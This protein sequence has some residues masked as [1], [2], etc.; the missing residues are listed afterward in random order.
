MLKQF[1]L[2]PLCA[3][4]IVASLGAGACFLGDDGAVTCDNYAA[5]Q[6]S[7]TGSCTPT[8]SCE[9]NYYNLSIN[10][11]LALDHCSDC[12]VDNLNGGYCDDCAYP[13]QGITS[14]QAFMEDLLGV[15]CW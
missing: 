1:R 13:S 7:C 9:D 3:A 2:L 4:L 10:D 14:C 12:L 15:D 8:W 6:R 11:Q 5:F